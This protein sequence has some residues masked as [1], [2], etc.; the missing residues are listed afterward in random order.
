MTREDNQTKQ[1]GAKNSS[2]KPYTTK[3]LQVEPPKV[4]TPKSRQGMRATSM[5]ATRTNSSANRSE[6]SNSGCQQRFKGAKQ[7]VYGSTANEPEVVVRNFFQGNFNLARKPNK[8]ESKQGTNLKDLLQHRSLKAA[9]Q[10][11]M[12][13][14]PETLPIQQIPRQYIRGPRGGFIHTGLPQDEK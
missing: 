7:S 9:P 11:P 14:R 6:H 13:A 3:Q 10:Q 12:Q 2:S 4:K 5:K 8:V 1:S